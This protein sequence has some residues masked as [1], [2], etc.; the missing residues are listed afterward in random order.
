MYVCKCVSAF[1]VL[2]Y[3]AFGGSVFVGS[4]SGCQ[5]QTGGG[6]CRCYVM[7]WE[8]E[9]EVAYWD[10]WYKYSFPSSIS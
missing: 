1:G 9:F 2:R 6:T 4:T 7:N 3:V 10:L 8:L 5:I